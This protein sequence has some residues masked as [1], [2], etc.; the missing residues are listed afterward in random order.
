MFSSSAGLEVKE[1][2]E[3]EEVKE[4][5]VATFEAE[6]LVDGAFSFTSFTSFTSA[7][8]FHGMI[9]QP[10]ILPAVSC[11]MTPDFLSSSKAVS[12]NLR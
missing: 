4:E 1:V 3:V 5:E 2:E 12:Q 11:W 9:Q 8:S 7:F 10:A 6:E